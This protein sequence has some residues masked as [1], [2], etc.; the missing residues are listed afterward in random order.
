MGGDNLGNALGCHAQCVVGLGKGVE[1]GEFR[2]D[3]AQALIVDDEQGIYVFRHLL[4]AVEGLI[5]LL[6][7]LEAERNRDDAHGEDVQLLAHTGY[8]GSGPRA[9]AATHT[10][11]DESHLGAVVEHVLDVV[12]G[13]LGRLTGTFGFVAGTESLLAQL[14]MHGHGR[15]VECLIVRVA[16]HETHV[17]DAFTIHVVDSVATASTHT[18][19]FDDAVLFLG[20]TEI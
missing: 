11:R 6:V 16:K 14:Q 13:L 17:V 15:V 10:G 19:H 2:I 3:F 8:H 7:A 9:C 5:D 20:F 1:Q 4:H 18:N 12:D